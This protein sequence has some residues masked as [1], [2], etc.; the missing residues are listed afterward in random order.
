MM[1]QRRRLRGLRS[2]GVVGLAARSPLMRSNRG[3]ANAL[4][5]TV[6]GVIQQ[7]PNV[8]YKEGVKLLCDFLLVCKV[9][10]TIVWDPD[11]L[12]VHRTDFDDVARLFTL[13]NAIPPTSCHARNVEQFCAIDHVIVLST[14]HTYTSS[15]DLET[16]TTFVLPQSGGDSG[17]HAW[18]GNLSSGIMWTLLVV[19]TS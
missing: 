10:S 7:R 8:V 19:V 3:P 4:T 13:Q 5:R 17:F 14:G 12:E 1:L 16:Q 11:T 18:W 15:L 6:L 2:P 9:Q